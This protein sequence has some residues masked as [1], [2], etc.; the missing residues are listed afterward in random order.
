MNAPRA[1][2]ASRTEL[3]DPE[4]LQAVRDGDLSA[5]GLLYDRHGEDVRRLLYRVGVPSGDLDDLVQETFLDVIP[6]SARF[7]PGAAVRPW[8]L[9]IAT[10]IARRH[11][12]T[13]GRLITRLTRWAAHPQEQADST[14][15]DDLGLHED[16]AR[17]RQ[18]LLS[19]SPRK[20]ETFVLVV[21]EGLSCAEAAAAL[22]VPT[23]TVWTRL[24]HARAELRHALGEVVP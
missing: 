1:R 19:L 17:A 22:G 9:G 5:L 20:R 18:A 6:A 11:R 12:R 2:G 24:H 7:R 16:A 10:M 4:L 3:P 13:V 8:L 14:P 21:L 23:A 15:E